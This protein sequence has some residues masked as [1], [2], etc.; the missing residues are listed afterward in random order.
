VYNAI[1]IVLN[2]IYERS[3]GLGNLEEANYFHNSSYGSRF[4]RGCHSLLH[5]LISG[6]LGS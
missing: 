3:N 5:F 6:D 2:L 4:K 1:N